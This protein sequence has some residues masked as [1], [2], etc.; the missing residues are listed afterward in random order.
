MENSSDSDGGDGD[1]SAKGSQRGAKAKNQDTKSFPSKRAKRAIEDEDAEG[2]I[3]GGA[4]RKAG[5][6]NKSDSHSVK[7]GNDSEEQF[8]IPG[9][10]I[11]AKE[12]E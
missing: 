9:H 4:G 1:G 12:F 5:G 6:D 3:G 7:G 11:K 10:T 2:S 8:F